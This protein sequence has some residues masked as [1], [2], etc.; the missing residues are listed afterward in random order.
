VSPET[1]FFVGSVSK[2]LFTTILLILV[3]EER[4]SLDDELSKYVQWPRGDE[5]TLRM[6][7]NHT[8]G[9]PEWLTSDAFENRIDGVPEFFKSSHNPSQILE[10]MPSRAPAFPPGTKQ[11]YSNTNGLLIGEIIVEVTG[12]SL[13]DVFDERLVK[14]VGLAH[15]YLYGEATVDRPRARGYCDSE[16]TSGEYDDCSYADEALPDSADGSVVATAGDLVR[17]HR[18]LRGGKLISEQ[19]WNAM[20]TVDPGCHNGLA[21]LVGNGPFGAYA[22]NIGRAMGHVA[23]NIYYAD[24]D[25]YVAVLLNH[26]QS[27]IRLSELVA[28][29]LGRSDLREVILGN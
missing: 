9:I 15:T 7:L 20:N 13:G 12:K 25:L 26:G 29:W 5:I 11:Q 28:P 19:S 22:G 18:A 23:F 10:M 17:Y 21:Y 24:H 2:N 1:P 16:S 8:S 6:L 14:P 3:D 27:Q 4:V